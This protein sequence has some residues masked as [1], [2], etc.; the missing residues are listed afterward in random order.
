[1]LRSLARFFVS[2]ALIAFINL[3]LLLPMYLAI[4][5]VLHS[6]TLPAVHGFHE[7]MEIIQG[8]GVILIG[9]GVALEER[10]SLR[11]IFGIAGGE[12]EAHQAHID[13]ECHA[14]G[15]GLLLFGLFSEIG[16]EMVKLPNHIVNTQGIDEIVLG[17]STIFLVLGA[18]IQAWHVVVLCLAA[19]GRRHRHEVET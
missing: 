11:T 6:L 10:T 18:L 8:M 7:T 2:P 13:H 3:I 9:W 4:T 14:V 5:E 12:D 19:L 16:V 15:V 17:I 1:M